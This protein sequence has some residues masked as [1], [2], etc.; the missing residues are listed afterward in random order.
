MSKAKQAWL[1]IGV[2]A[3]ATVVLVL[4]LPKKDICTDTIRGFTESANSSVGV[5]LSGYT[6]LKGTLGTESSYKAPEIEKLDSANF[7]VLRSCDVSCR[8][9]SECLRFTFRAPSVACPQEYADLMD[10]QKRAEGVLLRLAALAKQVDDAKVQVVPKV[11]K[12]RE[13]VQEL[14]KTPG[15]TGA[16]LAQAVAVQKKLEEDLSVRLGQIASDLSELGKMDK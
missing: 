11:R 6:S 9:L 1:G 3:A 14:E 5:I 12:A 8:I 7:A 10:K 13:E 4:V 15:A 2:I 16:R